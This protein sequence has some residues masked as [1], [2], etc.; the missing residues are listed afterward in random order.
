VDNSKRLPNSF[1]TNPSL[2]QVRGRKIVRSL[3]G[4]LLGAFC[5]VLAL[6]HVRIGQL[7]Q[8]LGSIHFAWV[9]VALCTFALEYSARIERWKRMLRHENSAIRWRDCACPL[10]AG[11]ATNNVLPF[12]VGD[13]LRT[14]AFN[15]FLGATPGVVVATL[16][17]ERILDV[18]VLSSLVY[19]V[20]TVLGSADPHFRAIESSLLIAIFVSG[21]AILF[22]PR[23]L[24]PI[25]A[26][27]SQV[28]RSF[29]PKLAERAL[30]EFRKSIDTFTAIVRR[31]ELITL[32]ALTAAG[33]LCEGSIF[34]FSAKAL[35]SLSFPNAS[36]VAF[37]MGVIATLIPSSPGSLGTFEFFV[38]LAM[39]TRGNSASAAA[40]YAFLV[41]LLISLPPIITGGLCLLFGA[42]RYV[43]PGKTQGT[44]G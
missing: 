44:N 2:S 13:I 14:F 9:Y 37:P 24:G 19:C 3:V 1:L 39:T 42:A 40:A 38:M 21:I 31:Q 18:L 7:E 25:F 33:W 17:L 16:I 8:A 36:W 28:L 43:R 5:L 32:L 4:S 35:P 41:H 27:L 10:L 11:Y 12:R 29:A 15:H 6:R 20:S 22:F 23:L 26:L 34:W 30:P